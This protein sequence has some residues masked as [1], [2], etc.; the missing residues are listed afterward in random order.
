MTKS[1]TL[2]INLLNIFFR[3]GKTPP[4]SVVPS[5]LAIQWLTIANATKYLESHDDWHLVAKHPHEKRFHLYLGPDD[6]A[7]EPLEIVLPVKENAPDRQVYL[8]SA[9]NLLAAL[10]EVSPYQMIIDMM[11][12]LPKV[13]DDQA[14]TLECP[15]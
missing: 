13:M 7:G 12:P 11:G 4:G 14:R 2:L 15:N 10:A 3:E 9:V 1:R 6:A 8:T 5:D